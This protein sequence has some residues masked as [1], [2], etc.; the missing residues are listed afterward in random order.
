[1][2]GVTSQLVRTPRRG[3]LLPFIAIAILTVGCCL[4]L[5]LDRL[6]L[7]AARGEL[8]TAAESAALA[9]AGRLADDERINLQTEPQRLTNFARD[10]AVEA[11][12]RNRC[13]GQPVLL[14]T[15]PGGHLQF[16]GYALNLDNGL[17]EFQA[18]ESLP[19]TVRC[20]LE[21]SRALGNPIARLFGGLTG[22]QG[23]D[24]IGMAEATL[25]NLVIG[26]RP[27]AGGPVP[28]L[29]LAIWERDPQGE[30]L[31]TWSSQIEGGGGSDNWTFD[32]TTR[33]VIA[34]SD[35]LPEMTLQPMPAGGKP[36]DANMQLV[37]VGTSLR[38]SD[39]TRQVFQ[40]WSHGDLANWGGEFRL[41]GKT[42]PVNCRADLSN[43]VM[44]SFSQQVGQ[45]RLALLYKRLQPVS[46]A[47][48]ELTPT[49]FVAVRIMSVDAASGTP[50]IIVQPTV[51]ATRTALVTEEALTPDEAA[52]WANPYLYKISLTY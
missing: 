12:S 10:V 37:G 3:S 40:G 32:H 4:A 45:K 1:M 41:D 5:V 47:E 35:G 13:G 44:Q 23:G 46:G 22:Q 17:R 50:Q 6:W 30:R 25:S 26:V 7:S 21:K 19:T 8:Q 42:L 31:D 15:E 24:A 11:A 48:G 38:D 39:L 18:R 2:L 34:G 28:A 29:P 36:E 51:V 52:D 9:A 49:R 16:G 14:N 27:F 33:R 43:D 20:R